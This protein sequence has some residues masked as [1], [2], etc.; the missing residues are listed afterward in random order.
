MTGKP[1][2]KPSRVTVERGLMV[3]QAK[4][5]AARAASRMGP[6]PET[7]LFRVGICTATTTIG[8]EVDSLG[9]GNKIQSVSAIRPEVGDTVYMLRNQSD[10]FIIGV[11]GEAGHTDFFSTAPS[12]ATTSATFVSVSSSTTGI[13]H[14]RA[15][16]TRLRVDLYASLFATVAG[17]GFELSAFVNGADNV[18]DNSIVDTSHQPVAMRTYLLGIPKGDHFMTL[19]IRRTGGTGT[20][21]MNSND[22]VQI[23]L[24]EVPQVL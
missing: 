11:L 16:D 8:Y 2:S 5:A 13:I 22:Y 18:I 21:T 1:R 4:Q 12:V 15:N 10:W 7:S 23:D 9:V 6:Q 14:K 20:L 24:D 3:V 19:R 17:T